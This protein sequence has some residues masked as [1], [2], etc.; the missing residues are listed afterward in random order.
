[1]ENRTH[2]TPSAQRALAA[3][4]IYAARPDLQPIITS[5]LADALD[6]ISAAVLRGV[7][8]LS[9]PE[10]RAVLRALWT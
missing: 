7:A 9:E 2:L 4:M 1:V 3:A 5:T 10:A 6:A 8:G